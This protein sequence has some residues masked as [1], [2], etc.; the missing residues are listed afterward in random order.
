LPTWAYRRRQRAHKIVST[1]SL[2]LADL[3]FGRMLSW[4]K[5]LVSVE[6]FLRQRGLSVE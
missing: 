3:T 6:K 4:G 1:G 5:P 2:H